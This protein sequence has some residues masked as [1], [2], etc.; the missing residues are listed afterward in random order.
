MDPAQNFDPS[1]TRSSLNSPSIFQGLRQL[2]AIGELE[3]IGH[4]ATESFEPSIAL[5]AMDSCHWAQSR[6]RQV[7]RGAWDLCGARGPLES[8][9]V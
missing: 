6:L 7:T 3:E 2:H 5:L 4:N 9:R 1:Q 8:A